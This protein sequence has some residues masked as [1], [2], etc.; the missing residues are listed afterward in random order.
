MNT[1]PLTTIVIPTFNQLRYTQLCLESIRQHTRLPYELIV[2]DNGS[3]DGTVEYLRA[4]P[5]L[6]LIE[7]PQNRGFA[8]ACNQGIRIARGEYIL[9]LN[10]DVV[11]TDGW[12]KRMLRGFPR[13]PSTGLVGPRANNISGRQ[14]VPAVSYKDLE[15]LQAF[16]RKFAR[17]HAGEAH[18]VPRLVGFCLLI[19]REVIQKIGTLDERFGMGCFEDDDFCLRARMA[20]YR[21]MMADDVFIHHFGSATFRGEEID[22]ERV[23]ERSQDLFFEKWHEG[24]TPPVSLPN[25]GMGSTLPENPLRKGQGVPPSTRPLLSVCMIAKDE[26]DILADSLRAAAEVADEIILVDTGSSD[27]TPEIATK[28]GAKVLHSSW[29]DDFSSAR[30]V[31]LEAAKGEWILV[32]DADEVIAPGSREILLKAAADPAKVGYYLEFENIYDSGESIECLLMRLFR[33][34]PEIRFRNVIHE[35]IIPSLNR[36]ARAHGL[37]VGT[38]PVRV[39]HRGYLKKRIQDKNK[40]QRNLLLYRKQLERYPNDI[41]S[42]YKYADFLR[43]FDK[44][45]D[46]F[47][48]VCRAYRLLKRLPKRHAVALPFSG[49]IAGLFALGLLQRNRRVVAYRVC[50]QA[51]NDLDPSPNLF[52]IAAAL[53]S[54]VGE[55]EEALRLYRRCISYRGKKLVI[56]ARTGVTTYLSLHGMGEAYQALGKRNRAEA[57]FIKSLSLRPD[58][59]EGIL[60]LSSLHFQNGNLR[61]AMEVLT[62]YLQRNPKS[63]KGW[64]HGAQALSSMGLYDHALKWY[65][66]AHAIEPD[67]PELR[68]QL[69]RHFLLAGDLEKAYACWRCNAAEPRSQVG[70]LLVHQILGKPIDIHLD[71]ERDQVKDVFLTLCRNLL[72][73]GHHEWLD[74]I[75]ERS[76]ALDPFLPGLGEAIL[77][78]KKPESLKV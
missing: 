27:R 43:K 23:I 66:S 57:F 62:N 31:S 49:D 45:L 14:K 36:Y 5:N 2:V 34:R 9:L 41:Y 44:P 73:S 25:P 4:A 63:V 21:L 11:V 69:G 22:L 65:S 8:S 60:S 37:R 68:F 58:F 39:V 56:P 15:G 71:F 74:R 50:R 18:F 1:I 40:D 72:S 54:R 67:S 30:N 78:R 77:Q 28:F 29:E 7:N 70:L 6:V 26:E 64:I 17:D 55:H 24:R 52:Y 19:K 3:K 46:F 53:A 51:V 20:G 12:L 38:L 35:Q 75:K 32:L 42:W 59:L 47:R 33:N 48:A 10:N 61:K 76:P 16:A 13:D